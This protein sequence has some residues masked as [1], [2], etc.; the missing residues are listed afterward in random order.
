M[1]RRL[2]VDVYEVHAAD[3]TQP[4]DHVG[5]LAS[6]T[7]RTFLDDLTG[8]GSYSLEVLAGGGDETLLA[9]GRLLRWSIDGTPRWWSLVEKGSKVS[10]DPSRR[11][12][13]HV[14][15]ETGR[16]ALGIL[17]NARVD[18]EL[19]IGSFC[20]SDARWF[21]WMS[22]DYD[23]SGWGS[24]VELKQ[25]SDPDPTKSWWLAP[26]GWPDADGWWVGPTG[27]DTPPI[28]PGSV[29]FRGTLTIG[30][31]DQG[32][33]VDYI[34]ADDGFKLY[35]DAELVLDRQEAGLWGNKQQGEPT[36][37]DHATHQYAVELIN[38]DRPSPSTNVT[39]L[40]YS[41]I[42]LEAGGA[43]GTV[44]GRS[45]S[46]TKMLAFP[47]TEPGM[48]P[49]HILKLLLDEAHTRGT[50]LELHYDFTA[51]LD[52][53]GNA[54]P[55]EVNLAV[56]VGAR[57]SEVAQKL[58]AMKV[59]TLR[60]DPSSTTLTLQAF[61]S[62]GVDLS[63][64][65]AAELAVNIGAVAHDHNG[66]GDNAVASKGAD[67]RWRETVDAA[68]VTSYRRREGALALSTAASDGTVDDQVAA[69][70]ADRA[71]ASDVIREVR[72]EP[73][74]HVPYVDFDKGDTISAPKWD[75]TDG[76]FL[77]TAIKPSTD[78]SGQLVWDLNLET[79]T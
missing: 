9:D 77:V 3:P 70:L 22:K 64:T 7:A 36:M 4:L 30:S 32:E 24:A 73:V 28:A 40:I 45:S 17:D 60:L 11:A 52:S 56:T 26:N 6:D 43:W 79:A 57:L 58:I 14:I 44:V 69:Y 54:W 35:R 27:G 16:G 51:T 46:G 25:Q 10:A 39:G 42:K 34:T 8:P 38:F 72:I 37:L 71:A 31:G 48:T 13:G 29:F 21:G 50:L 1:T 41:V 62:P 78:A 47:A 55:K 74:N 15:T 65:V 68:A 19:G 18:P 75:G 23:D 49:G 33:Y 2:V 59:V 20:F 61:A 67:G 66:P 63:G 76:D 5:T 12:G 53:A